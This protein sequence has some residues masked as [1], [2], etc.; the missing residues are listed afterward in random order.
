MMH[1]TTVK[2]FAVVIPRLVLVHAVLLQQCSNTAQQ[3]SRF[4]RTAAQLGHR[5][6]APVKPLGN[7]SYNGT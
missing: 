3:H 7:S 1:A 4:A 2:L 5:G 6:T